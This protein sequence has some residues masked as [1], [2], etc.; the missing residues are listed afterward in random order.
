M[1]VYLP[2]AAPIMSPVG[3]F[4][5]STQPGNGSFQAAVTT[6]REKKKVNLQTFQIHKTCQS[7]AQTK[8]PDNLPIDGRVMTIGILPA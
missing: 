6:K 3:P 5:P 4:M 1:K 8:R 2:L 7:E